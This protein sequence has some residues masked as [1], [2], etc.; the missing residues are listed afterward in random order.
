MNPAQ[1]SFKDVHITNTDM[2]LPGILVVLRQNRWRIAACT[3]AFA[4]LGAVY[5]MVA[6]PVYESDIMIQVDTRADPTSDRSMLDAVSSINDNKSTTAAESQIL[7]SRAIVT[8]AV[9]KQALFIDAKPRR[10]PVIG[11]L[12]ARY[13][14]SD[15]TP[16]IFGVGG[17]AWG[18]ESLSID[19]FDV[20]AKLEGKQFRLTLEPNH[21]FTLSGPA[22]DA[23]VIGE[24]GKLQSFSTTRGP[25]QLLVTGASGQPGVTFDLYRNSRLK[26]IE[27]IQSQL[28]IQEK[29]KDSGILVA[30]LRG[31]DPVIVSD[32]LKEIARQF[33]L[34]N[35]ERKSLEASNSLDFL[36]RQLPVLKT[37]LE[38]SQ[39][40]DTE[41]HRRAGVVDL[42][43]EAKQAIAQMSAAKAQLLA[44][45]QQRRDLAT[46]F[47]PSYLSVVSVDR[48][49]KGLE[50]QI[51]LYAQQMARF[52]DL[53]QEVARSEMQVKVDSA[54][55]TAL[56]N[57][58]QQLEL[59]KAG[60]VGTVRLIDTPAVPEDPVF[61]KKSIVVVLFS[62]FGLLSGLAYAF[63][64]STVLC[65]VKTPSEIE[66]ALGINVYA[67]I[68]YSRRQ[69]VMLKSERKEGNATLL[70]EASKADPAVEG[71]R[72]LRMTLN[73]GKD[74]ISNKIVLVTGATP[75]VGKSFV[76]ANFA[77]VVASSGKRV[78]LIDADL[79][80]G[81]LRKYFTAGHKQGLVDFLEGRA[82]LSAVIQHD[83]ASNL[84]FVATGLQPAEPGE[85]LL[86]PR[87]NQMLDD[88][89][90]EY[91]LV[92]VD[93]PPI[94]TVS[95]AAVLAQ[96]AGTVFVVAMSE[97]TKLA[98]LEECAKRM[99]RSGVR[100]TGVILNGAK[101]HLG[102]Y[103][104]A[105]LHGI[106]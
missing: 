87:L 83:A 72:A 102:E 34:Q 105:G 39:Q 22:L 64:R 48:Q 91:D 81:H 44:L 36:K 51:S 12:V 43:E 79:R 88:C 40:A 26:T 56:L 92:I 45:Q 67:T 84:D 70:A 31:K 33:I 9:D 101:L 32:T 17:F 59:V 52:P 73:H 55:Y 86:S 23:P 90:Q 38:K 99:D 78:L 10:F 61:P 57:N 75:G 4:L 20:P 69:R 89:A 46:R 80:N 82:G 68:P 5:A 35:M 77:R 7:S 41:L 74:G 28:S 66:R 18:R 49:I 93:A 11:S 16:G 19:K 54:L 58:A 95:D 71:L 85:L 42:P 98:E 94:L 1:L 65:G 62:L 104:Y 3:A 97:V 50:E 8:R 37:Q 100:I 2:D 103:G 6:P 24:I 21:R 96:N 30:K 76:S 60:K 106:A 29:V 27:R 15:M 25:I 13:L 53:Q 14:E 47:A 63:V